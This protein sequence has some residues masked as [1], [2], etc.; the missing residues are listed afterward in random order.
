[1]PPWKLDDWAA[2]LLPLIIKLKSSKPY[3][4]YFNC[5]LLIG[6]LKEK[7][8][9]FVG[10]WKSKTDVPNH[11]HPSLFDNINFLLQCFFSKYFVCVM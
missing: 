5:D 11:L 1:M 6:P 8:W 9:S 3:Y 2:A 10:S 7:N 4:K